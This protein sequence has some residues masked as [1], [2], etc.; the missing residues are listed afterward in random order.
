MQM[1]RW[2]WSCAA[3]VAMTAAAIGVGAAQDARGATA[4]TRTGASV[5]MTGCLEGPLNTGD[6]YALSFE[7]QPVRGAGVTR[8]RLTNVTMKPMPAKD[9]TYLI[10]GND[11]QLSAQ[12]GRQV[13]IVGAIVP[14]PTQER[15]VTGTSGL[16]AP[17]ATATVRA[18]SVRRVADKCSPRK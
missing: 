14:P 6:E 13:Q 11:E 4:D 7:P 10:V 15:A 9:A 2:M 16:T 1:K 18:Q 12:L 8:F 5:T 3:S 17:A